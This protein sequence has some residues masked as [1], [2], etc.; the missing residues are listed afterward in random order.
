MSYRTFHL[1][2]AWCDKTRDGE[3]FKN[4][5]SIARLTGWSFDTE[6]GWLCPHCTEAV[7]AMDKLK[8][9]T[10][11]APEWSAGT[12]TGRWSGK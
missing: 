3:V 6:R 1:K 5:V 2:C 11:P 4:Q 10:E 9:S 8:R 12:V 7:P